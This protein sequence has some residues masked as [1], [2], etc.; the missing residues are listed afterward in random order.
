MR[1]A[2]RP[3]RL[4][5]G[6]TARVA[7]EFDGRRIE[8]FAGETVATALLA[9]GVD[10]LRRSARRGE[11]RGVFCDMGVCFECLVYREGQAV[12][13]CMEPVR[14][15]MRLTSFGPELDADSRVVSDPQPPQPVET[16]RAQ[17]VVVGG[18]P[19]GMAAAD[20]LARAGI[21]VLVL[22]EGP[23]LG[24]QIFRQTP[25]EFAAVEPAPHGAPS[26]AAGHRLIA[27]VQGAPAIAVRSG[28]TVW[29]IQPRRLSASCAGRGLV[30]EAEHVILAV[31]AMDRPVPFPGWTLPGVVT[32]GAAQVMVRGQRLGPGRRAVVAGT[33]PLLLPTVTAL[34]SA[35]VSIAGLLE[36][37]PAVA[38][39]RML[40]ALTGS[41]RRRE[42]LHYVGQLAAQGIRM[43][44]GHAVFAARGADRL[45]SVV[46]GRVDAE[47]YPIAGSEHEVEADVLCTGFGLLPAV[48]L[49]VLAG[50]A[51]HHQE[52]RGGWLPRHDACM[53]TS[54]P[55]V[56]VAGEI[57]GIGGAEVAIAEG[58]LAGRA[59]A[60]ALGA[61]D[62]GLRALQQAR[63]RER[64]ASD[65]LLGA[66]PVLPGLFELAEPGTIVCRCED[67][68]LAEVLEAGRVFGADVKSVKM[69]TRAG[70][71]PCQARICQRIV[72]SL[73]RARA[74]STELP[75]PCPS[76]RPPVKPVTTQEFASGA[77]GE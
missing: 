14:E 51:M 41:A 37:N 46:V 39:L 33:G 74:G 7:F 64:A 24:G 29:D 77:G 42:A 62:T 45:E 25:T 30:V 53:A 35:G 60:V 76:V 4:E 8:A 72:G 63:A 36:A 50:C 49:A 71:G 66:F 3:E 19:A 57:A 28:V 44:F 32:A 31:G 15:G 75:T 11:P 52:L 70:M 6:R 13:A 65:A 40:P 22:D 61:T 9:A 17:V 27:A 69:A 2:V 26:H 55:G 5:A 38:L 58:R 47:G 21:A 67:V 43:R 68:T 54:V 16:L 1:S 18:G 12:R 73:L 23:R 20:E 10:A 56:W 48:E 34:R 59:V